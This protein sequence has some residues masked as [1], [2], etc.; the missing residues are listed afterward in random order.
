[1]LLRNGDV[2]RAVRE[3]DEAV[4]EY[5]EP[6]FVWTDDLEATFNP[7]VE[8][9]LYPQI[10]GRSGF[11][12]CNLCEINMGR[13]DSRERFLEAGRA[14]AIL[15]TLQADYTS[16]EYLGE[17]SERI[18]RREA[19]LGVS[20]TGMMEHPSVAFDPALQRE[21]A[22]VVLEVNEAVAKRIGLNPCARA[23][24]VKPAGTSSCI[25]GTSSGIHPH[26]SRRYFRR[27]QASED[28]LLVDFYKAQ[29]P[30]SVEKS[31]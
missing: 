3:A 26:H 7:C 16:F 12:F 28:E 27:A 15:G 9:G 18:A 22:R 30:L 23:T 1:M 20:M 11:A 24:C 17:V 2:A 4:R 25:L 14:A 5:G 8:I 31:V 10:D 13:V 19:L 21:V 29:N 6:G